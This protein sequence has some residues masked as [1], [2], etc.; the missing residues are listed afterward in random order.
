MRFLANVPGLIGPRSQGSRSTGTSSRLACRSIAAVPDFNGLDG[1]IKRFLQHDSTDGPQY[2]AEHPS[3]ERLAVAYDG[4]VKIFE[5]PG[6]K[7]VSPAMYCSGVE[8]VVWWRRI[9]D[10][11]TPLHG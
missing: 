1:V 3:L 10:I 6:P 9:V 5:R 8:V 7:S 4:R 11:R 2:E